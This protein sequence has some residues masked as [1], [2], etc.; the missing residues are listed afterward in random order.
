MESLLGGWLV[1]D[2]DMNVVVSA[3]RTTL[4]GVV[5][6][7]CDCVVRGLVFSTTGMW[8]GLLGELGVLNHKG[9]EH[10]GEDALTGGPVGFLVRVGSTREDAG[11]SIPMGF[12]W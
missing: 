2:G 9:A 5:N 4:R 12:G 11:S 8:L 1:S 6:I 7:R 10:C 3:V